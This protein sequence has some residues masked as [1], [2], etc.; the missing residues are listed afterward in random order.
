MSFAPHGNEANLDSFVQGS[1]DASEHRKRVALVVGI[2]KAADYG[3]VGDW[4]EYLPPL[5]EAL[6][7]VL[8]GLSRE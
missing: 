7:P 4:K 5:V 8:A 1:G 6:K 2:F 3:I